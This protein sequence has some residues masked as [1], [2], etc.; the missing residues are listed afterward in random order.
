MLSFFLGVLYNRG[1]LV[2]FMEKYNVKF[3]KRFGQ[4]VL[5]NKIRSSGPVRPSERQEAGQPR[6]QGALLQQQRQRRHRG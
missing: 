2:I 1:Q 6:G 3:K 5:L 4:N